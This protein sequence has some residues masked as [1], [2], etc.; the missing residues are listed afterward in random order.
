MTP[1]RATFGQLL[2]TL[3]KGTPTNN[4]QF[5]YSVAGV[6]SSKIAV[7]TINDSIPGANPGTTYTNMGAVYV[8]NAGSGGQTL[9]IANPFST[10]GTTVA[11]FGWSVAGL[12]G[13][14][15]VGNPHENYDG[16]PNSSP[17]PNTGAAYL[18]D[19]STAP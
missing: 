3:H 18:F 14:I 13:N 15:V 8:F 2:Q 1:I 4:D 9:R 16:P 19:G 6:G 11:N 5:G 7:G 12:G 10:H 17:N